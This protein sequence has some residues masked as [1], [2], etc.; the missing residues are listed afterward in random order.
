MLYKIVS[1]LLFWLHMGVIIF[2]V[3]MGFFLPLTAVL[4][5]IAL[6]RMQ[7]FV[8]QDCLLS[9]LQKR[10]QGLSKKEHFLQFAVRKIFKKKIDKQEAKKLDYTLIL[11]SIIIA[12]LNH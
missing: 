12:I 7:F 8:F 3:L 4:I 1:D 10:V 11:F 2:G 9:K 6:H 5:L